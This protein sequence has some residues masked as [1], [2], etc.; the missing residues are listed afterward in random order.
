MVVRQDAHLIVVDKPCG[1]SV[2]PDRTG[3]PCL[4][5]QVKA[6]FPNEEIGS[7]HRID[8]PVGGLVIFTRS[9]EALR[10]MDA[11]FR[12]Q[13]VEKTYLAIVEGAAP[14]E[15]ECRHLLE[16]TSGQR[17]TRMTE[18]PGSG[19][20]AVLHYTTKVVGERF[21]LLEVT[22]KGGAFHQIRAQLSAIRHPI[23]GDV[24]Y[25]ARRGEKDRGIALHAWKMC[26][27]HPVTN[28]MLELEAP[29]PTRSIWPALLALKGE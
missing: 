26:F 11:L 28:R 7:P 6:L 24:K 29:L 18:Q 19:K 12:A 1:I 3:D 20:E 27:K 5:D 10:G 16:H 25:G 14:A 23:K 2:Q 9:A 17:K 22:P 21:S 13:A 15:G 4:L 8:R